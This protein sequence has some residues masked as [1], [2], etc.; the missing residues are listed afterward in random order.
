MNTRKTICS[1]FLCLAIIMAGC[2]LQKTSAAFSVL[3][4]EWSIIELNG[5][6]LIPGAT[7][8][9]LIFDV[10]AGR[11]SG[12]AGCNRISGNIVPVGGRQ[13]NGI[14]FQGIVS[15][16]KACLDM[17]LEDGL[18]RA[19]DSVVRFDGEDRGKI[20]FYGTDDRRLFVISQT[21]LPAHL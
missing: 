9:L 4:G 10:A 19:L 13:K 21:H 17:R 8:Q 16:R 11:L 12:D 2:K 7:K 1:C 6:K 15:T 5:N 20:A 3:D 14:K 18:L